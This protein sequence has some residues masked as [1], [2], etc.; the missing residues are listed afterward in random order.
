MPKSKRWSRTNRGKKLVEQMIKDQ[1]CYS[2][3][4][5]EEVSESMKMAVKAPEN[6]EE[7]QNSLNKNI[8]QEEIQPAK[9][10]VKD[11]FDSKE[12]VYNVNMEDK[13]G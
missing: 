8:E 12:D 6:R 11:P 7:L 13:K 5:A 10:R 3:K 2:A 4:E 1:R 9:I